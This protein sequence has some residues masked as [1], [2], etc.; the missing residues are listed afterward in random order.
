MRATRSIFQIASKA[1]IHL[2]NGSGLRWDDNDETV[3]P[4]S[5]PLHQ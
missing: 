4:L 2:E 1:G 3:S 5:A